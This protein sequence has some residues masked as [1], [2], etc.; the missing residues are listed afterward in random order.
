MP[1]DIHCPSRRRIRD[2]RLD[3]AFQRIFER[4]VDLRY[5]RRFLLRVFSVLPGFVRKVREGGRG[6]LVGKL[7]ST[8][9]TTRRD[10]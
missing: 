8:D 2:D 4:H 1:L 5:I 9:N 6:I 3:P 10:C 7:T